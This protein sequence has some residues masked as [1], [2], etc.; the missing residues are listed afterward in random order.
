MKKIMVLLL[1]LMMIFSFAGCSDS[2]SPEEKA[3]DRANEELKRAQ[4]NA[5]SARDD[6]NSL[7]EAIDDY[8]KAV[9][10]LG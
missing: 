2:R 9:S 6:Y 4:D 5:K 10:R 8:K 1:S 3:L 7:K